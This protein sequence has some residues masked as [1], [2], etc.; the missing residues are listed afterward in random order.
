MAGYLAVTDRDTLTERG[1]RVLSKSFL[2]R[3]ESPTTKAV[4]VVGDS[5]AQFWGQHAP[6][7]SAAWDRP[8]ISDAI[9]GQQSA[10]IAARLGADPARIT[11]AGNALPASG[12]TA[13]T[14]LTDAAGAPVSPLR[15]GAGG[16]TSRPVVLAGV[17][18]TLNTIDQGATYTISRVA[19]GLPV[20]VAPGSPLTSGLAARAALPIILGPRNDIGRS[21]NATLWR[22]PKEKIL[23]RYRA[24]VDWLAPDGRYL[25]LSVLPW[26]DE[27]PAGTAVRHELNDALRDQHPQQWLDWST[28]LRTDA[29]FDAA[30]IDR[31]SQDDAD[32]ANGV[33]PTSFRRT[34]D[35]GHLNSAGYRAANALVALALD[36]MNA[37][38]TS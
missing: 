8:V 13:V 6:G 35:T 18:C 5:H 23:T 32:V 3:G 27:T 28:F 29:A 38:R 31:T 17:A 15:N 19:P 2:P 21:E 12:A 30:G 22:S 16:A 10:E 24:L 9:S 4:C 14:D 11:V 36:A 37:D 20:P 34:D 7:A 1:V 26:S 25:M 33:T